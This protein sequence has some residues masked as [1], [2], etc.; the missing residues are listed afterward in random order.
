MSKKKRTLR[1]APIIHSK[2][3]NSEVF[4]KASEWSDSLAPHSLGE[5]SSASAEESTI[6]RTPLLFIGLVSALLFFVLLLQLFHLQV[7]EGER[8]RGI[9]EGN[10]VREQVTY[11][12]RGRILDRNG[13]VLADNTASFQLSATPYLLPKE[14]PERERMYREVASIID[15]VSTQDIKDE[16]S[17]EGL[18]GPQPVLLAEGLPHETALEIEYIL[19]DL[20]GFDLN[21]V[22]IRDYKSDSGLSHILGYVG[23][24]SEEDIKENP[25]IYPIDFIGKLG[26]ESEY[27]EVLR[28]QNGVVETEVDALGRPLRTLRERPTEPGQ[29]IKLTIDYGLQKQLADSLRQQMNKAGVDSGAGVILDPRTGD[30]L[31]MVSLPSYDNNKFAKGI[32]SQEYQRLINHPDQL[33]FNR[34][35]AGGYPSGS[36]IKPISLMGALDTNTVTED[37]VINDTGSLVVRSQYDPSATFTFMGWEP[38]GLGPMDARRAIAMSSNIYFYKVAGGHRDFEGMGIDNLVKY[39]K[40]FGLG[41]QTGID[42]PEETAGRVPTPEW[43]K[44]QTGEEWYVG[45]TYNL[46]IGQGDLL[47]S[48][49]QMARAHAAIANNGKLF[50]PNL[51]SGNE[52][53]V[54]SKLNIKNH[55][56]RVVQ[57]GMRQTVSGGGTTSPATF[58]DVGAPVAGKSGTAET[59]PGGNRD[60]HAWYSAYAPYDDPQLQG[61]VLLEEGEGGSQYAAP[62]LADV[63]K[64]YFSQQ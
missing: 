35:A 37:T 26:V 61:V 38:E 45:D 39:Y 56:F 13:V 23:R 1:H 62:V 46:G 49:L 8:M 63:F 36:I 21:S 16:I 58:A 28:G 20:K 53:E 55:Y 18:D 34:A 27:D 9:A 47:V 7:A 24:V 33:M 11:A 43:K 48:P 40:K 54:T 29:D 31:A 5:D 19:P 15:D 12:P 14:A 52:P 10:R 17:Q 30:V 64:R 32:E 4:E 3:A 51:M 6:S 60:P 57:E 25:D 41:S 42:L 50:R 22:P 44:E 2:S 59:D